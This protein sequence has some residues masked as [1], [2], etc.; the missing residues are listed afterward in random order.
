MKAT[1][2]VR[3]VDNLGR[4]VLPKEIRRTMEIKENDPLEFYVEDNS[5]VLKKYTPDED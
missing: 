4:F 1:G 3:K 2:I 5:V